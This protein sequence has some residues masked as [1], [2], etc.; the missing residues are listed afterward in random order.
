MT[1]LEFP[2]SPA[3]R[4][5]PGLP[6]QLRVTRLSFAALGRLL[7]GLAARRAADIF[8]TAKRAQ[9]GASQSAFLDGGTELS[10]R[11][12]GLDLRGWRWGQASAPQ[13]LLQHGWEGYAGQFHV[14]AG[15]LVG[16]G[17]AVVAFDAPGHGRSPDGE[18]NVTIIAEMLRAIE[19]AHGPFAAGIGHSVG[20]AALGIAVQRGLGV[21]RAVHIAS[22]ASLERALRRFGRS[23]ALP[24]RAVTRFLALL[25]SKV[26]RPLPE[27]DFERAASPPS[28]PVLLLHDPADRE[29]PA[30]ESALV[31][32]HWPGAQ[33]RHVPGA[34]HRRVLADPRA[35]KSI[36]AFLDPLRAASPRSLVG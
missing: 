14:L 16:Q 36:A 30:S 24:S 34:G 5:A 33:L 28:L 21:S 26:D 2:A 6:L 13:I 25:G 12:G 29:V 17:F 18:A 15:A 27:L 31:A 7:P 35:L 11:F 20:G 23:I 10:L 3:R 1:I 9:I 8:Y 19:R 22:P 4:P 32:G